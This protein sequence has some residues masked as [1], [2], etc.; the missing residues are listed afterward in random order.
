MRRPQLAAVPD[1]PLRAILYI[2]QSISHDDSVSPELQETAG[3]DYCARR[4]Y[5]V[6]KVVPDRNRTGRTFKRRRV[7]ETFEDIEQGRAEVI[8]LWKWSRLSRR[9]IDWAIAIDRVESIGGRIESATEPVDVATAS[10]RLQ[11]G[12]LGEF[13]AFESDRIGETW[14]ETH[15][16]RIARGLPA[17]GR[18]RWGYTYSKADGYAPDPVTGPVLAS[19]YRRYIAGESSLHMAEWLRVNGHRTN[20]ANYSESGADEWTFTGLLRML[21]TGFGAGLLRQ[22]NPEIICARGPGRCRL[23]A[24]QRTL[25]GA[26]QA[27]ITPEEWQAY[28]DKRAV[29]QRE[30]SRRKGSRFPLSGLVFCTPCTKIMYPGLYGRGAEAKFRCSTSCKR[31]RHACVGGYI[32]VAVLEDE[33]KAWLARHAAHV[34]EQAVA[35]E[36]RRTRALI[37]KQDATRLEREITRLDQ[38][39]ARLAVNRALDPDSMPEVAWTQARDELTARRRDLDARHTELLAEARLHSKPDPTV[40]LGLL[41]DWDTLPVATC[42]DLL[43]TVIHRINVTTGRPRGTVDIVPT[44]ENDG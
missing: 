9:R 1:Q 18:P 25:P 13:A 2:R 6:V 14:Q 17:T 16:L 20:G 19:L 28:L 43:G 33:V 21:D 34:D 15:A 44:W 30:P 36:G 23:R 35:M 41:N 42:R 32:R 4:G 29:R 37:A 24:H 3:R 27:V 5:V 31:G 39:L 7:V 8:V 38:A 10:G 26:H 22:H 11:R 12:M 40:F